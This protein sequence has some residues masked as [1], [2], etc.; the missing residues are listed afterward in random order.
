MS[1]KEPLSPSSETAP[2]LDVQSR[3]S[4]FEGLYPRAWSGGGE[5]SKQT[6]AAPPQAQVPLDSVKELNR[7]QRLLASAIAL[8]LAVSEA[9]LKAEA[10]SIDAQRMMSDGPTPTDRVQ[11]QGIVVKLE[12]IASFGLRPSEGLNFSERLLVSMER[13]HQAREG[14]GEKAR[15]VV[16]Q[17]FLPEADPDP[18]HVLGVWQAIVGL[19]GSLAE[20]ASACDNES[21]AHVE[22]I[23]HRVQSL[24]EQF[25]GG[26][27]SSDKPASEKPPRPGDET[28]SALPSDVSDRKVTAPKNGVDLKQQNERSED[29]W[30]GRP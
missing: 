19:R 7:S 22:R 29:P 17:L 30:T 14:A 6:G 11:W 1:R 8:A 4:K 5:V 2:A 20:F 25:E 3:Q 12:E 23:G 24:L 21:Q 18:S 10:A 16:Q 27:E 13:F 28:R 15:Q 26:S 9:R